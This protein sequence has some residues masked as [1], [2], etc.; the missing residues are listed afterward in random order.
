[1]TEKKR[2]CTKVDIFFNNYHKNKAIEYIEKKNGH[3][4]AKITYLAKGLTI[5]LA[6]GL[7]KNFNLNSYLT[8]IL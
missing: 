7:T 1:M 4:N 8:C 3:K 6:I 5:Y 2:L